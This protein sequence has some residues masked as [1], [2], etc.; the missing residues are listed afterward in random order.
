MTKTVKISS[1]PDLDPDPTFT[2]SKCGIGE[3]DYYYEIVNQI[4]TR[5]GARYTTVVVLV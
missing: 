4:S 1:D 2:Q 3:E 5:T